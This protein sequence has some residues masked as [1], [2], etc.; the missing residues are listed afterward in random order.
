MADSIIVL[1]VT[2]FTLDYCCYN[3]ISGVWHRWSALSSHLFFDGSSMGPTYI[4]SLYL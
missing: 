1:P 3:P 2:M 4:I